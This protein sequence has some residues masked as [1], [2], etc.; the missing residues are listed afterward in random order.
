MTR[1]VGGI[2]A[3]ALGAFVPLGG[4]QAQMLGSYA[5]G[6]AHLDGLVAQCTPAAD[7]YWQ[8]LTIGN[9]PPEVVVMT[10]RGVLASLKGI[11]DW[12][13]DAVAKRQAA[14]AALGADADLLRAN[15]AT[16]QAARFGQC[17]TGHELAAR[18]AR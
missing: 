1:W 18:S 2:A 7:A 6:D 14:D 13:N 5:T 4:A 15:P 12:T 16:A 9:N 17:L 8:A 3:V 11:G 10:I